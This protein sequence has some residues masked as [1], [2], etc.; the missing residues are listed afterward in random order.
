MR[1][2]AG[3]GRGMGLINGETVVFP[4]LGEVAKGWI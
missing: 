3:E 1:T 4:S 2:I